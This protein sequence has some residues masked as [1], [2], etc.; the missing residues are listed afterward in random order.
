MTQTDKPQLRVLAFYRCT[1][2][3]HGVAEVEH[4]SL[5]TDSIDLLTNIENRGNN[6]QGMK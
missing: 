5:R 1:Y 3:A 2:P 4:I 6:P